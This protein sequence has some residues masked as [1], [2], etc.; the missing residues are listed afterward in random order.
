MLLGD[1]SDWFVGLSDWSASLKAVELDV[2]VRREVWS[3][4]SVGTVG[5]ST[6]ADGALNDDVVDDTLLWVESSGLSVGSQ[7]DEEFTDGL[8]RLLGPATDWCLVDVDL[9]VSSNATSVLSER[10]N[11]FVSKNSLHV[12]DSSWD[13]HALD[14]SSSF[15]RVLEVSSEISDLAFRG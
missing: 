12:L 13:L 10:N 14:E 15:V 7:V 11:L 8:D 9:S 6:A 5:S 2:A 4:T 3:N 1:S